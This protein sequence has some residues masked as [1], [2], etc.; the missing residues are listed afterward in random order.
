MSHSELNSTFYLKSKTEINYSTSINNIEDSEH[1]PDLKESQHETI[2][3]YR[4]KWQNNLPSFRQNSYLESTK[5]VN[6]FFK[7]LFGENIDL[8]WEENGK[9]YFGERNSDGKFHGRGTCKYKEGITYVGDFKENIW[10]GNGKLF[11]KRKL[12]YEGQF[13]QGTLEGKGVLYFNDGN[14]YEGQFHEGDMQGEG[15]IYYKNGKKFEGSFIGSKKEGRGKMTFISGGY[16]E[17][18]YV[19]DKL[20]GNALYVKKK[21]N[22]VMEYYEREYVEGKMVKNKRS[23]RFQS[24]KKFCC[25]IF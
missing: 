9:V 18:Y 6:F 25:R 14:R 24:K 5:F 1:V 3:L 23:F 22:K 8:V 15:T 4:G 10:S 21:K 2:L 20:H 17:G 12:I 19:D 7:G 11:G 16:L 13:F